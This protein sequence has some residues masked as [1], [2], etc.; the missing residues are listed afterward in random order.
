MKTP[1][2]KYIE[3]I[4]VF[5]IT[6]VVV[7]ICVLQFMAFFNNPTA[8]YQGKIVGIVII[9]LLLSSLFYLIY[10]AAQYLNSGTLLQKY[11]HQDPCEG[12]ALEQLSKDPI[13][14]KNILNP[15]WKEYHNFEQFDYKN[16]LNLEYN[17]NVARR[18]YVYYSMGVMITLGI[19]GTFIGLIDAVQESAKL[20]DSMGSNQSGE[21]LAKKF[22][23]PFAGMN[24]AF[25]TSI[26]GI[27]SAVILGFC[28][29]Y[30]TRL[31]DYLFIDL[32]KYCQLYLTPVLYSSMDTPHKLMLQELKT[33]NRNYAT[34]ATGIKETLEEFLGTSNIQQRNMLDFTSELKK[35]IQNTTT[36]IKGYTQ[37]VD[38]YLTNINKDFET[39]LKT[40]QQQFFERLTDSNTAF[41]ELM[42][43]L[44][45]QFK[46]DLQATASEIADF[47]NNHTYT[48]NEALTNSIAIHE[49]RINNL[50]EGVSTNALQL[51]ATFD[52]KTAAYIDHTNRMF[53]DRNSELS[54]TIM[55]QL[56]GFK[57]IQD[58]VVLQLQENNA[59]LSIQ[60]SD[61]LAAYQKVFSEYNIKAQALQLAYERYTDLIEQSNDTLL[62]NNAIA[63]QL[64]QTYKNHSIELKQLIN[65]YSTF[66]HAFDDLNDMNVFK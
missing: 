35:E 36:E 43:T 29:A 14:G 46:N 63:N 30:V 27:I 41:N 34:V 53:L 23:A 33:L 22:Q 28:N 2:R 7:Y 42:T 5:I 47:L 4:L 8:N 50:Y 6:T 44:N 12:E 45:T 24:T 40:M 38:Q 65:A 26:V 9:S 17:R 25:S 19:L 56:Q 51:A 57:A 59:T 55:R 21:D 13:F 18:S 60:N 49:E 48:V 37:V 11:Y 61:I 52:D 58:E 15:I 66:T 16:L 20:L 54:A 32:E 39:T 64:K 31:N 62:K 3:G 1:M 10:L